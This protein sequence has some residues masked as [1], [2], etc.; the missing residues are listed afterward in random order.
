MKI[1][2]SVLYVVAGLFFLSAE[3]D[4]AN[5]AEGYRPGDIAPGIKSLGMDADIAFSNNSGYYTLLHFWAAYDAASRMQNVQLWNKLSYD[6]WLPVKMI[7]VSLDELESIFVETV[8]TDKLE[9]TDQIHEK[10]GER[11]ETY[12]KYGLKKGLRNFLIDDNGVI[13]ATG[14]TPDMLSEII[15][16]REKSLLTD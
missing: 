8:K 2:T 5:L 15:S 14:V 9:M 6:G 12:K 1:R 16:K 10:L 13:I 11:S 3:T 4:Q 7:S